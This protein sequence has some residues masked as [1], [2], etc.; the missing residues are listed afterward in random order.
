MKKVDELEREIWQQIAAATQK[1]D[2]AKIGILNAL[3]Q[4]VEKVKREV[5]KIERALVEPQSPPPD[6]K[7]VVLEVTDGALRQNYLSLTKIRQHNLIPTNGEEF[8]VETS[9]GLS[10]RTKVSDNGNWLAARGKTGHFYRKAGLKGGD[11]ILW[12]EIGPYKYHLAKL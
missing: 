2:S 4:D 12:S 9:V 1:R 8:L 10:F 11:K 6:G 3:A 5:E 7:S